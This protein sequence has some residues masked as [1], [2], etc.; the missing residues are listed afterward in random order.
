MFW[1]LVLC[2]GVIT[3]AKD[4]PNHCGNWEMKDSG[5]W[6]TASEKTVSN[7]QEGHIG[8]HEKLEV[9]E[10]AAVE[11]GG[12]MKQPRK[13]HGFG[14]WRNSDTDFRSIAQETPQPGVRVVGGWKV[15]DRGFMVLIRAYDPKDP[16]SY[17]TCGGALINDRYVLT[18][19]HCVCMQSSSSNVEC[20]YGGNFR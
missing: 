5:L 10:T 1:I 18:A 20:D 4:C 19:G 7:E 13:S 8:P 14:G 3:D 17:E 16:E 6:G 2:I 15:S 9:D 12:L 11:L